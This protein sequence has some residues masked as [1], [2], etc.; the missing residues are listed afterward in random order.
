MDIILPLERVFHLDIIK[1]IIRK[2]MPSAT[3]FCTDI[4][5]DKFG[6]GTY[7]DSCDWGGTPITIFFAFNQTMITVRT[8]QILGFCR[9]LQK[10][11]G[12]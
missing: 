3:L 5:V 1:I 4:K 11:S 2:P 9:L 6:S 10:Y 12:L 7:L 8:L